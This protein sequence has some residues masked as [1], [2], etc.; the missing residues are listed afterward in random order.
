MSINQ[1]FYEQQWQFMPIYFKEHTEHGVLDGRMI[2]PIIHYKRLSPGISGAGKVYKIAI[3]PE[4][5]R[6]A[7]EKAQRDSQPSRSYVLKRCSATNK[8][9]AE[10][11]MDR[12]KTYRF[13]S[14]KLCIGR[15][16]AVG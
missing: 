7:P 11:F 10:L 1:E 4:Y 2:L 16:L 5:D 13:K 8:A 15:R 9:E 3:H 12:C 14:I 6:P